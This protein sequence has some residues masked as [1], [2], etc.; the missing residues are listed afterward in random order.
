MTIYT[1]ADTASVVT[2]PNATVEKEA[3]VETT[4][5][6]SVTSVTYS[7][8]KAHDYPDTDTVF[9]TSSVSSVETTDF[10]DSSTLSTTTQ[11]TYIEQLWRDA[12][13]LTTIT[14]VNS[15]EANFTHP[16]GFWGPFDDDN[17]VI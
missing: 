14:Q 16:T 15:G 13:T 5:I 1:D 11:L 2:T 3:S 12:D 8:V 10:S 6:R 4:S 17:G 9:N 7:E